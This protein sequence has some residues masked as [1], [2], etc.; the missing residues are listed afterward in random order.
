MHYQSLGHT[1]RLRSHFLS[2]LILAGLLFNSPNIMAE[3]SMEVVSAM[4]KAQ[5]CRK[6]RMMLTYQQCMQQTNGELRAAIEAK[7]SQKLASYHSAKKLK[8]MDKINAKIESNQL[9]CE[10][11][12]PHFGD[13]PTG[14]RRLPYCIYENMLETLINID[15]NINTYLR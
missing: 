3:L 12:Q 4:D 14:Q 9:M 2:S 6:I 11:E 5:D 10:R 15:R 8:I 1:T 7:S 13:S